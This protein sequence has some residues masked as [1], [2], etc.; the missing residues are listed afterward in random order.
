M[1]KIIPKSIWKGKG[2]RITETI[3][4][5]KNKVRGI[6]LSDFKTY[7]IAIVIKTV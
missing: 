4:N 2:I 6:T 1:D 3:F 5:K 7:Y